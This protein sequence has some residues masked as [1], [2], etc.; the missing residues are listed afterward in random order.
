MRPFS[1]PALFLFGVTKKPEATKQL[2]DEG[3]V[4]PWQFVS[5]SQAN[6]IY[7]LYNK[8][9]LKFS[10]RSNRKVIPSNRRNQTRKK[11]LLPVTSLH[12]FSFACM[13]LVLTCYLHFLQVMLSANTSPLISL[14]DF[15]FMLK[16]TKFYLPPVSWFQIL[17]ESSCRCFTASL[18][19]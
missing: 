4:R 12:F 15:I 8:K 16:N 11:N 17:M 19:D 7:I 10:L 13:Y 2:K 1:K 6:C 14:P 9:N 5:S 3:R 18:V